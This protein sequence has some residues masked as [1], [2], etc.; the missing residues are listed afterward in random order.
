M[1]K[2]I[3]INTEYIKLGQLLK[4]VGTISNGSD[5]KLFI[6]THDIFV[7][8]ELENRRGRKIYPGYIIKYDNLE[9]SI[10]NGENK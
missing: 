3:S 7:N 10:D 1:I 6:E 8:N 4:L 5:S 9:I 2:H